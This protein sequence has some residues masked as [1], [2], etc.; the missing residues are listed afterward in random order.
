M[1]IFDKKLT[2][3]SLLVLQT[4]MDGIEAKGEINDVLM[5]CHNAGLL[6]FATKTGMDERFG[7]RAK[8]CDELSF[9]LQIINGL[10][11]EN[12]ELKEAIK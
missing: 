4:I 9:I 5:A 8:K 2:N 11:I 7:S 3:R 12:K 1:K 6:R 10:V